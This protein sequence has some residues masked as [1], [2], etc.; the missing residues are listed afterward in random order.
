MGNDRGDS[1]FAADLGHDAM[2]TEPPQQFHDA[3]LDRGVM[4]HG[5]NVDAAH[6]TAI[7][8]AMLVPFDAA[9]SRDAFDVDLGVV[10]SSVLNP[11]HEVF[12]AEAT[13][14]IT[15]GLSDLVGLPFR[16]P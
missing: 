3:S 5:L 14:A 8:Y 1:S 9:I 6:N 4:D 13:V 11:N 10:D 12:E 2:D 16:Q 7:D 15:D